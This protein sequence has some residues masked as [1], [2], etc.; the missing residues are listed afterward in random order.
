MARFPFCVLALSFSSVSDPASRSATIRRA[1]C[2]V[3]TLG[4]HKLLSHTIDDHHTLITNYPAEHTAI[5]N[6]TSLFLHNIAAL[7]SSG[8][9]LKA[10]ALLSQFLT[11]GRDCFSA[12]EPPYVAFAGS[13]DG[14]VA[15][16]DHVGLGHVFLWNGPDC[17]AAAT[18]A[19]VLAKTF[20][21]EFDEAGLYQ[22][23]T[24]GHRLMNKTIF[25]GVSMLP[26]GYTADLKDGRYSLK[27]T[28]EGAATA[29]L[30]DSIENGRS[31]IETGVARCLRADPSAALE[32]SGGLDSRMVLAAV[33]PELR[34]GRTAY[35]IGYKGSADIDVAGQLAKRH[36]LALNI[37]DLAQFNDETSEKTLARAKRLAFRDDFATNVYDRLTIDC[38]DDILADKPRVGGAN[39]EL[40]RGFYYAAMPIDKF[41]TQEAID[42]LINF[43]LV[44]NDSMPSSLLESDI[45][46]R[47][48]SSL[49]DTV[50]EAMRCG[51]KP[52]GNALDHFY[53]RQRMRH[54]AGYG[55]TRAMCNRPIFA[56]F[57]H[58]EYVAWAMTLPVD[59]KRDSVMFS[60]VLRTIDG[61]LARI[62]LDTGLVPDSLA[63]RG[64]WTRLAHVRLKS[65]KLR[66]KFMQHFLG[67]RHRTLGSE[68]SQVKF[69]RSEIVETINWSALKSMGFFK[70]NQLDLLRSGTIPRSRTT[71]GHI[72][73]LNFLLEYL[74]DQNRAPSEANYFCVELNDV[75]VNAR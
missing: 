71:L 65:K 1:A 15:T 54:W 74:N 60:K 7:G 18:S 13:L 48:H 68:Q 67:L 21:C 53:L 11:V 42:R 52:L 4:S 29:V 27:R 46:R 20:R 23:I 9:L 43:R 19:A 34:E 3:A 12:I 24:V 47:C 14:I 55:I 40:S 6:G 33:P 26:V 51:P 56:P 22:Q 32:L 28:D 16:A 37:V 75:R 25:Q 30:H 57:F 58:S 59:Y 17:A 70:S 63:Q 72:L 41:P 45:Y 31:A 64:I 5:Q 62:P 2:A 35:T 39:G 10:P 73:P 44:T 66:T 61:G 38:V 69:S 50:V 49:R 8:E 36:N